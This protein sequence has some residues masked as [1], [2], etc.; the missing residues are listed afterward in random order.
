MIRQFLSVLQEQAR[1]SSFEPAKTIRLSL[2]QMLRR[3]R[4]PGEL[5]V[6]RRYK[7]RFAA[8][9]LGI[10]VVAFVHLTMERGAIRN[11]A[12]FRELIAELAQIQECFSVIGDIDY[13][14]KIVAWDLKALAAFL[15][16]TLQ[17]FGMGEERSSVGLGEIKCPSA[18]LMSRCRQSP[19]L[20]D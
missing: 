2:T 20:P 5:G 12:R 11:M 4:Y 14:L 3:H 7:A 15:R 1:V 16:D 9:Q 18:L 6:I 17:I 8:P 19:R 10:G 13:V